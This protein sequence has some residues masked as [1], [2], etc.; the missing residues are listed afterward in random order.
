M[1]WENYKNNEMNK[2]I[3]KAVNEG[4]SLNKLVHEAAAMELTEDIKEAK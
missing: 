3:D 1:S 4:W 2:L